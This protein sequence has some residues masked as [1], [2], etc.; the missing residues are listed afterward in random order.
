MRRV[1]IFCT[2]FPA[3]F[4][5]QGE[6]KIWTETGIKGSF[7]KKVDWAV[8][9]TNRFGTYGLETFFPQATIRYKLN[10][11]FRPSIDYRLIFDKDEY[12]NFLSSQRLNFNIDAKYP[13]KRFEIGARCR[14]Q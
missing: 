1:F 3:F 8:E 12:T 7:S 2:F 4:Y 13:I 6:G 11:Y 14:Y 9:L 5:A 10:K